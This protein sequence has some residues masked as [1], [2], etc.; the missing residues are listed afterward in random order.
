[1]G[2]IWFLFE[3]MQVPPT[4][5]LFLFF[6][7]NAAVY[8]GGLKEFPVVRWEMLTVDL[9]SPCRSSPE[10]IEGIPPTHTYTHTHLTVAKTVVDPLLVGGGGGSVWMMARR[11]ESG[12]VDG[13]WDAQEATWGCQRAA[14]LPFRWLHLP[15]SSCSNLWRNKISDRGG[16][17]DICREVQAEGENWE[18]ETPTE[19]SSPLPSPRAVGERSETLKN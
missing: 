4:P 3:W 13:S 5:H 8:F 12:S 17:T 9:W 16:G 7:L 10:V 11:T 18:R 14:R 2:W 19:P 1:M 6:W 15:T